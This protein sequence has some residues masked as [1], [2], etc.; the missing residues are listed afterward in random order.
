MAEERFNRAQG[1]KDR[2]QKEFEETREA[3]YELEHHSLGLRHYLLFIILGLAEFL[4][5]GIVFGI[6]GQPMWWTWSAAMAVGITIPWVAHSVSRYLKEAEVYYTKEGKDKGF[7]SF[8]T[9]VSFI[10]AAALVII[11]AG[12]L[13]GIAWL[14]AKYFEGSEILKLLDIGISP[15]SAS[16]WLFVMSFGLFLLVGIVVSHAAQPEDP[17]Y[18]QLKKRLK[19]AKKAL[20]RAEALFNK[21]DGRLCRTVNRSCVLTHLREKSFRRQV[22]RANE[23]EGI[24]R[25]LIQIYRKT[26][27]RSRPKD[28]GEPEYFKE[29]PNLGPMPETLQGLDWECERGGEER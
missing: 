9:T 22:S 29:D 15:L 1:D 12:V 11:T 18:H 2:A 8:I 6:F 26:N 4:L 16:L 17:K 24:C 7:F 23:I 28:Q 10:K 19:E 3:F 27:L 14:R 5:N 20:K 21:A 13:G 25:N